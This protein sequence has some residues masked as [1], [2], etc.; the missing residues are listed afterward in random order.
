MLAQLGKLLEK[1]W[2]IQ[3]PKIKAH[4]TEEMLEQGVV[5]PEH[6]HGNELADHWAGKGAEINEPDNG[7]LLINK[8]LDTYAWLIQARIIAVCQEFL[9]QGEINEEEEKPPPAAR[10]NLNDF[11]TNL[12]HEVIQIDK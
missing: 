10:P 7:T 8:E 11:I 3:P 2:N 12:G 1:G 6:A 4:A 5:S 9:E